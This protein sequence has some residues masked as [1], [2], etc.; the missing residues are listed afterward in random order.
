MR[1]TKSAGTCMARYAPAFAVLFTIMTSAGYLLSQTNQYSMHHL[2]SE[3]PVHGKASHSSLLVR[4]VYWKLPLAGVHTLV[5]D[6]NRL[7]VTGDYL[8]SSG[9]VQL[10]KVIRIIP[11]D[12]VAVRLVKDTTGVWFESDA[13]S[14]Y[15][16]NFTHCY[17]KF[18][19]FSTGQ[20]FSFE[21]PFHSLYQ[22]LHVYLGRKDTAV[23]T[24]A[25]GKMGQDR[26]KW[27]GYILVTN[28]CP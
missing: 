7:V 13:V 17:W 15:G 2:T 3:P 10:G 20:S 21:E 19:K 23:F 5:L 22:I 16:A 14:C 9:S 1:S 6:S 18:D 24:M 28:R 11:H 12:L 25:S 26:I 27:M 8:T 4:G